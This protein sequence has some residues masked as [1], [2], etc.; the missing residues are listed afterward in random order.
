MVKNKSTKNKN[1]FSLGKYFQN[2]C[3]GDKVAILINP[4]RKINFPKSLQGETG[5]IKEKRGK[6]YIVKIKKKEYILEPTHLK[7]IK[8]IK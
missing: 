8:I 2:L 7:K 1:K 5:E 3:K 4:A 6:F